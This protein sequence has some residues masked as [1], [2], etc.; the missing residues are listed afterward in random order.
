MQAQPIVVLL[1][2]AL[3]GVSLHVQAAANAACE[4]YASSAELAAPC[5]K[6]EFV[7]QPEPVIDI[8]DEAAVAERVR[9]P[10]MDDATL[11]PVWRPD[12]RTEVAAR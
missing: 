1:A 2:H 6:R 7:P 8:G 3:I 11:D 12:D 4:R 9:R 5:D 10:Q